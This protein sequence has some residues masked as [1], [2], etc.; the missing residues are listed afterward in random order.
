MAGLAAFVMVLF[1]AVVCFGS[2]VVVLAGGP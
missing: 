2:L 1:V